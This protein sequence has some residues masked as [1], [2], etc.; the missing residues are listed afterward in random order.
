L[1]NKSYNQ[2]RYKVMGV[3]PEGAKFKPATKRGDMFI[4][5]EIQGKGPRKSSI[6]GSS[7]AGEEEKGLTFVN[8]GGRGCMSGELLG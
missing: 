3:I 4:K 2:I 8:E 7:R 6:E 5:S 1:E